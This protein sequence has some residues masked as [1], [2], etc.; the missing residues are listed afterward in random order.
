MT[1][2][3]FGDQASNSSGFQAWRTTF[4]KHLFN[5]SLK[6]G[7]SSLKIRMVGMLQ[8]VPYVDFAWITLICILSAWV[9]GEGRVTEV[10]V[11]SNVSSDPPSGRWA[12]DTKM[13]CP[14]S[15]P[16]NLIQTFSKQALHILRNNF[17]L[18]W[19]HFILFLIL[20]I[21]WLQL[22]PRS[23]LV[24]FIEL[25][26]NN[27]LFSAYSVRPATEFPSRQNVLSDF[28]FSVCS[29]EWTISIPRNRRRGRNA[30]SGSLTEWTLKT[31]SIPPI[32][33]PSSGS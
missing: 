15:L 10:G 8:V 1:F 7:K 13:C 33:S 32:F 24:L 22:V 30:D 23:T 29:A 14:R 12:G 18:S 11:F 19:W 17:S 25:V 3:M 16:A 4:L 28:F 5:K 20:L 21:V 26:R 9:K 6:S 31:D 2:S 27:D